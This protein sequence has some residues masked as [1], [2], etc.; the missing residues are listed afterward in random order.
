MA[1]CFELQFIKMNSGAPLARLVDPL[2][3][4][5]EAP[6]LREGH[7]IQAAHGTETV[8]AQEV[9]ACTGQHRRNRVASR[10]V[11]KRITQRQCGTAHDS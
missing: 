11:Y 6:H 2:G 1:F 4:A 10:K 9:D 3:H 7:G 8:Q 5:Q